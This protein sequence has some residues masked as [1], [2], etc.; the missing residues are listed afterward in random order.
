MNWVKLWFVIPKPSQ[1]IHAFDK[2]FPGETGFF[3]KGRDFYMKI[4][5]KAFLV[6]DP[7]EINTA[8]CLNETI[9]QLARIQ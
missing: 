3:Q 4:F 9:K 6:N 2:T 1:L 5:G 8:E 7:E